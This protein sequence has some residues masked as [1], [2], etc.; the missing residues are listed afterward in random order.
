MQQFLLYR[1]DPFVIWILTFF[2]VAAS[3]DLIAGVKPGSVESLMPGWWW[4]GWLVITLLGSLVYM[5]GIF[6]RNL[7]NGLFM[8]WSACPTL[9]VSVGAIAAAQLWVGGS[10]ATI[11]G[12]LLFGISIAF[13]A[14]RRLLTKVVRELPRKNGG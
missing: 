7:L 11:S 9:A 2:I 12:G 14:Q 4:Y 13:L 1:R 8:C 5:Y 3:T 10:S 6:T